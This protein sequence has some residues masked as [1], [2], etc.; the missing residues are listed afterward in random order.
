MMNDQFQL[1]DDLIYLNHAAVAPWPK[2]TREAVERFAAE[3][4]QRGAAGYL[5]WL[6]IEAQLR[7]RLARLINAV[8][9]DDIALLKS[10]SEALSTVAY[11]L[12]WQPGDNVVIFAQEFPSNRIVWESLARFGV[13]TRLVDLQGADSPEQALINACDSRT[14]LLSTSSVQ[15]ATG[16]R[17]Q[18]EPI[19][20]YC[21]AHGILFCVDAIQS[22]GALA[23]DSQ[24]CHADFVMA[25]GHKWML[26]PE[27]LALFYVRPEVRNR[28]TLHQF[29]WHMVADPGN[30]D[31]SDWQPADTAKRFECGSPNML[32]IHALNASLGAIEESGLAAI[33]RSVLGNAA[34]LIEQIKKEPRLTLLSSEDPSRRSGIVT[35]KVEGVDQK[36]VY[37]TLM[38][39]GIICA[40][41]GGGIRFSPHGYNTEEQ[42]KR[43]IQTITQDIIQSVR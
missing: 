12:D 13:Q 43:A 18:L 4:V 16:M 35:F 27:G 24:A 31:A 40:Y 41:R 15:Y 11:G 5:S 10:T 28:L 21:R 30:Y 25:D 34:S 29:G 37:E 32:G 8:S 6:K 1:D 42:L 7:N 3:N 26:G 23:F 33:E 20:E 22:L 36:S 38:Q 2:C 14:R 9:G 17:I 19:G 39:K